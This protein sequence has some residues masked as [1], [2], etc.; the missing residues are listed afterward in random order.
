MLKNLNKLRG[1]PF[2]KDITSGKLTK[3]KV[4]L[5]VDN[6]HEF[7]KDDKFRKRF[8]FEK[9][10]YS[11]KECVILI[12]YLIKEKMAIEDLIKTKVVDERGN[13][14]TVYH[15]GP[16]GITAFEG[17]FRN[18]PRF[19]KE[20]RV[21]YDTKG[22]ANPN[23]PIYFSPDKSPAEWAAENM[24]NRHGLSSKYK[25]Y[26][27]YL[28]VQNPKILTP[29]SPDYPREGYAYLT[30][31]TVENWLK[32]GYDGVFISKDGTAKNASE[33]IVFSPN[34]LRLLKNKIC[35]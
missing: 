4:K 23:A 26:A 25:I 20:G 17:R 21:T 30:K 31:E 24:P 16:E 27:V 32:Q 22:I 3:S 28:D 8:G 14:L 15:G 2:V 35:E 12:R 34:R 6:L 13:P 9:E 1:Y 33:I 11:L 18:P 7:L 29:E 5:F 19:E 10:E